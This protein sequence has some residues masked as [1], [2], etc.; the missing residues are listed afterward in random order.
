MTNAPSPPGNWNRKLSL[1]LM[2]RASAG[3]SV[4]LVNHHSI[5]GA[6]LSDRRARHK[7]SSSKLIGSFP[8]SVD[9]HVNDNE[10]ANGDARKRFLMSHRAILSQASV[11][12]CQLYANLV[13]W[14]FSTVKARL[15]R[16]VALLTYFSRG[17]PVS[18][19]QANWLQPEILCWFCAE[20]NYSS[21]CHATAATKD[22]VSFIQ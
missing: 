18:T 2:T 20:A 17:I 7:K 15:R 19:W 13:R 8:W 10:T 11:T 9:L 5:L 14:H 12:M 1:I 4:E 16:F 21:G 22:L 3:A 6:T